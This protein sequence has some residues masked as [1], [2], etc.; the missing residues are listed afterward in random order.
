MQENKSVVRFKSSG[1]PLEMNTKMQKSKDEGGTTEF[2]YSLGNTLVTI[3]I[4]EKI[5]SGVKVVYINLFEDSGKGSSANL[6]L[7]VSENMRYGILCNY[8]NTKFVGSYD[9]FKENY[10][11]PPLPEREVVRYFCDESGSEG[12]FTLEKK[13]NGRGKVVSVKATHDFIVGEETMHVKVRIRYDEG[14]EGLN[15]EVEGPVKLTTDYMNH[16]V[17]KSEGKMLSA[18][19]AITLPQ[20]RDTTGRKQINM[21]IISNTG[22]FG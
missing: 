8:M 4:T 12:C 6:S 19:K 5:Y 11:A 13:K 15:V 21:N 2:T 20:V 18:I 7:L 14:E 22:K 10:C 16:V 3:N 17:S 1:Y 9:S